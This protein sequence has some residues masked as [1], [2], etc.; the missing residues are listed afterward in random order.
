VQRAIRQAGVLGLAIGED[1]RWDR[2]RSDLERDFLQICKRHGLP[3]PE[4]NMQVDIYLVD[5]LWRDCGLA[6]ETD[7]YLYHRGR[8][9]FRDD[10]RRD[11]DL[12][13]RGLEVLRL[14][15]EQVSTEPDRIATILREVL[16]SRRHRVGA[17]G[18]QE[19]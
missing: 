5:F 13:A 14:S 9:A 4:V 1:L 10:R 7:G 18:K 6:V 15:E 8:R 3:R 19:T 11:L 2:S 16:A 17:D 12:R